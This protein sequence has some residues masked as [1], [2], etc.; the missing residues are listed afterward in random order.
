MTGEAGQAIGALDAVY[1]LQAVVGQRTLS[2]E[3]EIACDVSG[4][5]TLSVL[6]A[7]LILQYAV[8]TT[9]TFPVAQA[10][11]S[12]WAFFPAAAPVPNQLLLQPQVSAQS[13]QA[14]AIGF[15]PLAAPAD[16]QD[17][18]AALFGDCTG[19]WQPV[20]SGADLGGAVPARV[21]GRVG[22]LQRTRDDQLRLPLYV[23]SGASFNALE[24]QLLYDP[25]QLT[26]LGVRLLSKAHNAVMRSEINVPGIIRIALASATPIHSSSRA[27]MAIQFRGLGRISSNAPVLV[28]R[29]T[30]DDQPTEAIGR[31]LTAPQ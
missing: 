24:A 27:V 25:T 30:I 28:S 2:P 20:S 13:C 4:N 9:T 14:G 6:D 1:V 11:G 26:A 22:H 23:E 12:D 29:I 3:Q 31:H 7:A 8:G 10:C 15:R 16:S 21:G 19:H 17:F 5:G 18:S